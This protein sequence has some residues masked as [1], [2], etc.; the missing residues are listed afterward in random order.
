MYS[1]MGL[2]PFIAEPTAIPVKPSAIGC[3]LLFFSKFGKHTFRRFVSTIVF[4]NLFT[5]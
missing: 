3:Q 1:T 2:Q 4:R 5:H